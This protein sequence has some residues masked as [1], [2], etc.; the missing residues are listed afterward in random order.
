MTDENNWRDALPEEIQADPSLAN[1]QDVGQLAK[2]FI[3]TKSFQGNSIH[4]PGEDA[5][6]EQQQEF[7][8]KL[9]EKAPG[10]MLRPDMDNAEQSVEFFR[11]LGMP[12]KSD[13]Y[14]VPEIDLPDGA[15]A[16]QSRVDSFRNI[17][18]EA[19]LTK[20]Q[21]NK[22]MSK[23][24]EQDVTM[25][26]QAMDSQKESMETLK[27]E[28]GMATEERIKAAISIAE[29]TKAPDKLVEGLKAGQIPADIVKWVYEMSVSM[30]DGEGSNSNNNQQSESG[31]MSPGEAQEKINEIYANKEH[32]FHSGNPA[33]IKRMLELVKAS[34]PKLSTDVNSLAT[35][36]SFG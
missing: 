27:A 31:S 18:H 32:P 30:G 8:S 34:N 35:G 4:I 9:L 14:E 6:D 28:W 7:V 21:F 1:F 2:S 5:G 36:V 10:V 16:D 3:D 17:A 33:A 13:G 15:I 20:S 25:A 11:T 12:E 19:G 22:V 26:Q 23:V 29:R 24:M